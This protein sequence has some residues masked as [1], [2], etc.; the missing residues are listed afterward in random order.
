MPLSLFDPA[1]VRQA[2]WDAFRKLHPRQVA[3]NPSPNLTTWRPSAPGE[4]F[5]SGPAIS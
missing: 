4:F 1:I 3:K 2:A 5:P